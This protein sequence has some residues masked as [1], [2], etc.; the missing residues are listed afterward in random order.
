[1]KKL[2]LVLWVIVIVASCTRIDP[3]VDGSKYYVDG[4]DEEIAIDGMSVNEE[5]VETLVEDTETIAEEH[6]GSMSSLGEFL[7]G[8]FKLM[9]IGY[10][11]DKDPIYYNMDFDKDPITF[12]MKI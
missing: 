1:M 7:S 10:R 2:I 4:Y 12:M 11:G 5:N 9:P 6:Q 8:H 3:E